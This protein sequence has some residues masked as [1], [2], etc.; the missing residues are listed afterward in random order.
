M[1]FDYSATAAVTTTDDAADAVVDAYSVDAGVTHESALHELSRD[2]CI[3]SLSCM[4]IHA[5]LLHKADASSKLTV[6][7]LA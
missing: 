4:D 1:P 6:C 3:V 2:V 5:P 7:P